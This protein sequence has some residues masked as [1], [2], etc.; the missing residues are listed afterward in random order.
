MS[1]TLNGSTALQCFERGNAVKTHNGIMF[2]FYPGLPHISNIPSH[3]WGKPE[4]APHYSTT[5]LC[6]VY[7]CWFV[8]TGHLL[9][10]HIQ[11]FH[12][13]WMSTPMCSSPMARLQGR[14]EREWEQRRFK[15]NALAAHIATY[16]LKYGTSLTITWQGRLRVTNSRMYAGFSSCIGVH[17]K[18]TS[19][20]PPIVHS[21]R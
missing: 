18:P 21:A 13:D 16:F 8:W 5:D 19:Y 4:W 15:L 11:R 20:A 17:L 9:N 1:P 2:N 7:A 6:T 12:N 10:E 3:N 14:H